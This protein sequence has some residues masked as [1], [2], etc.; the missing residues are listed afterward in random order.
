MK[1]WIID[2]WLTFE[3]RLWIEGWARHSRHQIFTFAFPPSFQ[4]TFGTPSPIARERARRLARRIRRYLTGSATRDPSRQ[5]T[6]L[7]DL[8][9]LTDGLDG[10]ALV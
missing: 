8:V 9:L 2:P 7:P 10:L 4:T 6:G 5:P 3:R 1:I